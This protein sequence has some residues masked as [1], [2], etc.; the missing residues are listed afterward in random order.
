MLGHSVET[1]LKY[2]SYAEK[3][4]LDQICD[5]LDG[6]TAGNIPKL[7]ISENGNNA[8]KN[9]GPDTFTFEGTSQM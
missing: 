2:Y 7:E 6:V 8:S 9:A 1:N 4:Y 5:L 3:E